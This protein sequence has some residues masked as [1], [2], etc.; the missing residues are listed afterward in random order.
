MEQSASFDGVSF[1][2][3]TLEQDGLPKRR[4]ADYEEKT[5]SDALIPRCRGEL[6]SVMVGRL[7]SS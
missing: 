5:V 6:G 3:F 7:A 2:P 1:D 4:T